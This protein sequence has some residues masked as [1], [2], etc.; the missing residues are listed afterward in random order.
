M[1]AKKKK[2]LKTREIELSKE[3]WSATGECDLT[4]EEGRMFLLTALYYPRR[5]SGDLEHG[6]CGNYGLFGAECKIPRENWE[7]YNMIR[8]RD[9]SLT[10]NDDLNRLVRLVSKHLNI[11]EH[12]ITQLHIRKKSIDARKKQELHFVYAIDVAL[13][14]KEEQ[15][16][17]SC[18]PGG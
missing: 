7:E 12:E 18:L 6:D 17:S 14:E 9:L 16:I 13:P 11:K 3:T 8:I 2:V 5:P 15:R 1:S 4:T 10:P